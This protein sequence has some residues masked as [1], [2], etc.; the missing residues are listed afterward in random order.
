V[1]L[2]IGCFRLLIHPDY[3][4]LPAN[5]DV[6]RLTGGQRQNAPEKRTLNVIISPLT[7]PKKAESFSTLLE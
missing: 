7:M 4:K 5:V 3:T 2:T 6:A 1:D